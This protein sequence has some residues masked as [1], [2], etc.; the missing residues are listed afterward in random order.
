MKVSYIQR[1]DIGLFTILTDNHYSYD[2]Q[3]LAS[4]YIHDYKYKWELIFWP[5]YIPRYIT[6]VDLNYEN[7]WR[8]ATDSKKDIW[9]KIKGDQFCEFKITEVEKKISQEGYENQ[10]KQIENRLKEAEEYSKNT[11]VISTDSSEQISKI[12]NNYMENNSN[13]HISRDEVESDVG[14]MLSMSMGSCGHG[15]GIC[16]YC[17]DFLMGKGDQ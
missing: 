1:Y 8:L 5:E 15:P 10:L 14:F 3:N 2:I 7:L 4:V 6:L 12:T 17:S 13:P 11:E 16:G 9:K